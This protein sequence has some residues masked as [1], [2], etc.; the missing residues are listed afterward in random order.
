M[1][2][3]DH[4]NDFTEI[5]SD[6]TLPQ[7]CPICETP[8]HCVVGKIDGEQKTYLACECMAEEDFIGEAIMA[9]DK[10]FHDSIREIWGEEVLD[11]MR[12]HPELFPPGAIPKP[13]DPEAS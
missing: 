12:T 3:K 1:S 4:L 6:E 13:I 10:G 8:I 5:D 2:H 9:S 7:S 11:V